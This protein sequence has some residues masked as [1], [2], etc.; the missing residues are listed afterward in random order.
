MSR[1]NHRLVPLALFTAPLLGCPT[2]DADGGADE[3]GIT[4]TGIGDEFCADPAPPPAESYAGRTTLNITILAADTLA[5]CEDIPDGP[6]GVFKLPDGFEFGDIRV[7]IEHPA[8]TNDGPLPEDRFPLMVFEHGTGQITGGYG[9]IWDRLVRNGIIVANIDGSLSAS[10][11]YRGARMVCV[12]RWLA[13]VWDQRD[14]LNCD[15][16]IAGHSSGGE[17]TLLATRHLGENPDLPESQ[18]THQLTIAMASRQADIDR[19]IV[20]SQSV[21]FV[22]FQGSIDNDVPG[23]AIRNYDFISPEEL[24]IEGA[25]EKY[26]LWM[27]D[28]EHEAFGGGAS[29][30]GDNTKVSQAEVYAEITEAEAEVKG[31]TIAT[32]YFDAATGHFLLG[33]NEDRAVLRGEEI[34]DVVA[35]NSAWWD[36]LPANPD[37]RPMIFASFVPA[38]DERIVVDLMNRISLGQVTPSSED[39]AVEIGGFAVPEVA[40]SQDWADGFVSGGVGHT[41]QVMQVLW[42]DENGSVSWNVAPLDLADAT[43]LSF[44]VANTTDV[45]AECVVNEPLVPD[46]AFSVELRS[47]MDQSKMF[48]ELGLIPVQDYYIVAAAL[49]LG[50]FCSRR[51]FMRTVRIPLSEYCPE[52]EPGEVSELTMRF[53]PNFG[54]SSGRILL[55]T[56]EFQADPEVSPGCP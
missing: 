52:I 19:F 13:E 29:Q 43:H 31:A 45:D 42:Q 5:L 46:L 2:D 28:V 33:R 12:T 55:D 25:A 50:D 49:G 36:Y 15:L 3:V 4:D 10:A 21:P 27:Y 16:A 38:A 48:G 17:A 6:D 26:L 8:E 23:G 53:G 39:L 11:G 54:S 7:L 35:L 51:T 41:T 14:A 32:E 1:G 9:H 30:M 20:A 40:V 44:R 24:G 37:D 22:L 47:E 56:V 18:F 34:P